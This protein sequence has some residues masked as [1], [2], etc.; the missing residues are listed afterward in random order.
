MVDSD[1]NC[2]FFIYVL[3]WHLKVMLIIYNFDGKK[4]DMIITY[5]SQSKSIENF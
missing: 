1:E 3:S 2:K 5:H 4:F